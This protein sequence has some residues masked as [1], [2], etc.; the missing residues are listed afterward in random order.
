ML[1][2]K[3]VAKVVDCGIVRDAQRQGLWL[4]GMM[5]GQM[6]DMRLSGRLCCGIDAVSRDQWGVVVGRGGENVEL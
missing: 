4:L 6:G 3:Q 5:V 2:Q 1:G